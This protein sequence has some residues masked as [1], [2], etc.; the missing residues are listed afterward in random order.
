LVGNGGSEPTGIV[1]Y[2]GVNVTALGRA[3]TYDDLINM[4]LAPMVANGPDK[5][6]AFI[7]SPQ[8]LIRFRKLKDGDG[9]YMLGSDVP[10]NSV[11]FLASTSCPETTI[12]SGDFTQ[13][14]IGMRTAL[15]VEVLD[16]GTGTD[17]SGSTFNATT[18]LGKW[19][20]LYLRAD[21]W[22]ERPTWLSVYTGAANS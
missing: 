18:Q 12:F 9:G 16:A 4:Q 10:L 11:P 21:T 15:K 19:L 2:T 1:S 20:R 5:P 14:V 7:M 13:V 8:G 17:S 22:I 6:T 3:Y